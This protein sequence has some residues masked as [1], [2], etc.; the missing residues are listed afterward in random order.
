M[1]DEY[2]ININY[3]TIHG[4]NACSFNGNLEI[5]KFLIEERQINLLHNNNYG[6]LCLYSLTRILN[7]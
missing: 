3:Q 6:C 2:K 5:V 1:I 7:H 4:T